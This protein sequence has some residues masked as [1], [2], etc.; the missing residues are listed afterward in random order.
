MLPHG[1]NSSYG[2]EHNNWHFFF[3]TSLSDL[4]KIDAADEYYRTPYATK[5][6]SVKSRSSKTIKVTWAKREN[7]LGYEV[8]CDTST[9]FKKRR[10]AIIKKGNV[11][12]TT[13][14]NLKKGKKYYVRIRT[15]KKVSGK[16]YYSSWSKLKSTIVKK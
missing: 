6:L 15:Y 4:N 7:V 2:I 8:Q 14:S 5:L 16:T 12:S 11:D 3:Y 10:S 13:I 9:K 1:G